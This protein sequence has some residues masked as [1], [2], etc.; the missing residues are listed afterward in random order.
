MKLP[1]FF[2]CVELNNLMVEIGAKEIPELKPVKFVRTVTKTE[3][4]EVDNP[5]I[6]MLED[7][8][9]RVLPINRS[10][11]SI[12]SDG[13]IQDSKGNKHCLYI[14]KQSRGID[15]WAKTTTYKYHLTTCQTIKNMTSSGHF[16]RYVGTARD[17]G[18][19]QVIDQS[20]YRAK[21]II[22]KMELCSH[23][24][25]I[26]K[27]ENKLPLPFSLKSYY[28]KYQPKVP[29]TVRKA[30]HVKITEK[31]AP[32]HDEVA[33]KY[34]EQISYVCQSCG[35]DCTE[36][37]HCLH[38][39]HKNGD[40]QNNSAANLMVLCVSCHSKQPMHGHMLANPKFSK[41]I[42]TIERKRQQ[43]GIVALR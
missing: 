43:Q 5:A 1:D 10:S 6:S 41:N 36:S 15:S 24:K 18:Y 14:M 4:V 13:L 21:E 29:K 34:K 33:K 27:K 40:G 7:L 22:I 42:K 38:L 39:H 25:S 31:Y 9:T 8:K 32:N 17:D 20:G 12:D 23:C 35:V 19:F 3:Y 11:F 28:S 16:H 2:K 26:L 30:E 37:P